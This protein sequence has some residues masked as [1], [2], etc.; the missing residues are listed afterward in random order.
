VFVST[1][2][3]RHRMSQ[4]ASDGGVGE[5]G[6]LS[7]SQLVN[8]AL[9]RAK[10]WLA[11]VGDP[12]ALCSI[13][14]CGALWRTYLKHCQKAG[15]IHPT[16]LSLEDIWQH[17]QSL[18]NL[19]TVNAVNTVVSTKLSQVSRD[20]SQ[21]IARASPLLSL[22]TRS[23]ASI[24]TSSASSLSVTT[25]AALEPDKTALVGEPQ[26]QPSLHALS[27]QSSNVVQSHRAV[28]QH[29]ATQARAH[30]QARGRRAVSEHSSSEECNSDGEL[31]RDRHP[32]GVV[33]SF[34]EWSLDYQLEPDEIIRQLVKVCICCLAYLPMLS[35][36]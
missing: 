20:Q 10:S 9:T 12:V 25:S 33:I 16:D 31:S 5:F 36:E 13:G 24:S 21:D 17:S 22:E 26:K 11:V 8:T 4:M 27:L 6:F 15:G 23:S 2:R 35:H 32:A 19:L 3:S 7:E 1:V 30:T 18:T 34:A 28:T 29:T 14:N